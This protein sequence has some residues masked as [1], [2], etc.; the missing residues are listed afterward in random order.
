MIAPGVP[1]LMAPDADPIDAAGRVEMA[2]LA[3]MAGQARESQVFFRL[4]SKATPREA[5]PAEPRSDPIMR[6][7]PT[8]LEGDLTTISALR[9]ADRARALA[10]GDLDLSA[11]DTTEQTRWTLSAT[12]QIYGLYSPA[13]PRYIQIR[14]ARYAVISSRHPEKML[15]QVRSWRLAAAAGAKM[16]KGLSTALLWAAMGARNN[17]IHVFAADQSRLELEWRQGG[18]AFD[19]LADPAA[20]LRPV[21]SPLGQ[22]P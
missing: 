7:N 11:N 12:T 3:R 16:C 8:F 17:P 18:T 13:K 19:R 2:R 14:H 4:Q 22:H 6:P 20:Q 1:Q 21:V 15:A 5:V 9:A 10:N